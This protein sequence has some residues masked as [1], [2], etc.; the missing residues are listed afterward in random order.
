[1][2]FD[3]LENEINDKPAT[4]RIRNVIILVVVMLVFI[5]I[6]V[7]MTNNTLTQY[8]PDERTYSPGSGHEEFDENSEVSTPFTM[9]KYTD[10]NNGF[11]VDIP[12]EWSKV[13]QNGQDTFIHRDSR[14]SVQ[15]QVGEYFPLI[16][17]MD[18]DSFSES[19]YQNGSTLVSFNRESTSSY[20]LVYTDGSYYY[21]E[22][23]H[24]NVNKVITLYCTVPAEYY[25]GMKS[26]HEVINNSFR[27]LDTSLCIPE[28]YALRYYEFGCFEVALP[29]A[30]GWTYG[31][32]EDTLAILN[33]SIG[34]MFSVKVIKTNENLADI[35]QVTY[36]QYMAQSYS[37]FIMQNFSNDGATLYMTATYI[38]GNTTMYLVQYIITT[39]E[40]EYIISYEIPAELMNEYMD[41][42]NT[43]ISYFAI[44]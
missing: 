8:N 28:D 25:E 16:N 35:S 34:A 14:A 19:L 31:E 13:V 4:G 2:K 11:C 39:G 27:W 32:T 17:N 1:M 18:A 42:Y 33:S 5:S 10:E 40:F 20:V 29:L 7:S 23:S 24:W 37:N 36:G 30:D 3:Y 43:L 41:V 22:Y 9:T 6:G 26:T 38:N 15:L 44:F 12:T 21:T